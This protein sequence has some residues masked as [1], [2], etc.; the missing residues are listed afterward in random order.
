MCI[1]SLEVIIQN[2]DD[3]KI[4]L[5]VCA[6]RFVKHETFDLPSTTSETPGAVI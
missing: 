1:C 5:C 3:Q 6:V 2:R 4:V